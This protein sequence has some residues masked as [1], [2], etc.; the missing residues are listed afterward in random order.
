[1]TVAFAL[2]AVVAL[3]LRFA[4]G[5]QVLKVA[6][7]V[8]AHIDQNIDSRFHLGTRDRQTLPVA[9]TIVDHRRPIELELKLI[10]KQAESIS[11]LAAL[12]GEHTIT[13]ALLRAFAKKRGPVGLVHFDAHV[14]TWKENFGQ[15]YG[16]GSVFFHAI[17]GGLVDPRRM[18][19][20]GILVREGPRSWQLIAELPSRR[21]SPKRHSLHHALP[22]CAALAFASRGQRGLAANVMSSTRPSDSRSIVRARCKI[23]MTNLVYNMRR[24]VCLE[25]MTAA[26]G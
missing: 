4:G 25:R 8:H 15:K 10:E 12:G 17:E 18:I 16:H 7:L 9:L 19:Q 11:H 13:L 23:G 14:D 6:E 3:M 5:P 1:L 2:I 21:A 24:F 20:I 26:A 22:W